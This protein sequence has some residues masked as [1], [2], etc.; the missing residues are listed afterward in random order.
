MSI[1]YIKLH[2]H[3][4]KSMNLPNCPSPV[5]GDRTSVND[6]GE[7]RSASSG[8]GES[9]G[10]G[11]ESPRA[12]PAA[13]RSS[14][15][16]Q[17]FGDHSASSG[18]PRRSLLVG[19]CCWGC[20]EPVPSGGASQLRRDQRQRKRVEAA[21][22]R[23][24]SPAFWPVSGDDNSRDTM[25]CFQASDRYQARPVKWLELGEIVGSIRGLLGRVLGS[26]GLTSLSIFLSL[27]G[28]FLSKMENPFPSFQLYNSAPLF[29]FLSLIQIK[30]N[31][32]P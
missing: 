23:A 22:F 30:L 1:I 3:P 18:R 14:K 7:L 2:N 11:S 26:T 28:F 20:E 4:Q 17:I 12:L 9:N 21:T 25:V 29:V 24:R 6:D 27:L 8:L 13:D 31:S 5:N 19:K 10:G 15:V 32:D 16:P